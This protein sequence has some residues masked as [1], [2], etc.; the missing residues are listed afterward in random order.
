MEEEYYYRITL[1]G[2]WTTAQETGHIPKR[3]IDVADGYFHLSTGGQLIETA[4]L[5]FSEERA[6][7]AL[8]FKADTLAEHIK[9][10]LAPKRQ[11]YF[12]H[13]Y[14]ELKA[15]Q[16]HQALTLEKSAGGSFGI[17]TK[18]EIRA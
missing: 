14:G 2:E 15:D 4:N 9:M 17:V 8:V 3:E 7:I 16:V 6:L 5:H 13:Y 12:P 10:E 1:P 18:G 11:Q